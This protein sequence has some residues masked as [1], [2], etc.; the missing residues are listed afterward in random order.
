MTENQN[1]RTMISLVTSLLAMALSMA[2]SFFLSPYIV[3]N[4][5]E[6]ANGF[7]QLANNFVNYATLITVA[8]NSMA[9]RFITIS[10]HRKDIK[11]CNRYYSSVVLGNIVIIGVL[12]VPAVLCIL[13]LESLIQIETAVVSH[14]KILF[15]FVFGNF[16]LSQVN[17][18]LT[19]AIYVKNVQYIQNTVNMLR[20]LL[21]AVGLII[22]FA[23]AIPR[24]FYV[25]MVGF[26]LSLITIPLFF[27]VKVKILPEVKFSIKDFDIRTIWQML[28]SGVWN[29]V[30]QCGNLLMTGFDLLISNWFIS[31]V[32]MGVLSVAKTIPNCIIQ[33]AG[34]V[35]TNFSPN[36]TIA[37]AANDKKKI[38]DSLR[39]AMKC[40]SI[41]VA[42]PIMVMCVYGNAFY[43]L[44]VPSMDPT[45]LTVLSFLSCAAFVPFAGPQV[46]YNVYTTAN[47]LKVNALS[48]LVGGGVNLLLV[49]VLLKYT[50]L[51]LIAVAGVSSVVSIVRNLFI[52]VPYTAK[53]LDL[54]WYTFYKDVL[55]STLCCIMSGAA[56]YV[57]QKL[58]VPDSWITFICSAAVACVI[59]AGLMI[60][61]LLNKEEKRQIIKKILRR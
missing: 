53:I 37:Y 3:E 28:S 44:W 17:G 40:S 18:I 14:V 50:D 56:C 33:L 47:K 15:A 8:L 35:N 13:K 58:I 22:I 27:A 51:G 23:A 49:Y 52:T 29:T 60:L 10:Y 32:Q 57:C 12:L 41:L 26:V 19:I 45:Q 7:T 5:G 54:K 36:L 6:E 2:I 11:A 16:F 1:K 46:L 39:Y 24:I 38:L 4:F 25:S 59:S 48:V 42:I 31:P 20:T 9:G 55:I 61:I 34:T 21:N 43:S 30:N